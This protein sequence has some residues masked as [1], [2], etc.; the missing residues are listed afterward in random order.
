MI[1]AI[2]LEHLMWQVYA[3][4]GKHMIL[5]DLYWETVKCIL[6]THC[7]NEEMNESEKVE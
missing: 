6:W 5:Y 7:I 2:Y 4:Y 1:A 3:Q